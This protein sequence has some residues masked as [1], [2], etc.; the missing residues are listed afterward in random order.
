MAT[1][2]EK[3]AA[4]KKAA[5]AAKAKEDAKTPEQRK[6]D[7]KRAAAIWADFVNWYRTNYGG[8]TPSKALKDKYMK[9]QIEGTGWD[10]A[11]AARWIRINDKNYEETAEYKARESAFEDLYGLSFG[12]GKGKLTKQ[13]LKWLD[14]FG[15]ADPTDDADA[16]LLAFFSKHIKG[17]KEF[18]D[19]HPGFQAFVDNDISIENDLK[20][21]TAYN[22]KYQDLLAVWRNEGI[23]GDMDPALVARAMEENWDPAGTQ[24]YAAIRGSAGYAGT[25]SYADRVADFKEQWAAI[26]PAGYDVD[27]SLMNKY[28]T[29]TR[30]WDEFLRTDIKNSAVFQAAYPDYAS[31][32]E[33]Q[34]KIGGESNVEGQVD[35]NDYFEARTNFIEAWEKEYTHGEAID[36][37]LLAQA[38]AG[39]WSITK[40]QNAMRQLPGFAQTDEGKNKGAAF[41]SYWRGLFGDMSPVDA[42]LRS[43][44]LTGDYTDPSAMWDQIKKSST[45]QSQYQNWD[46]YATAQ[47]A[48]G[49]NVTEDPMAYKEYQAAF[50]KAFAD[51]GMNV[52][53]GMDREIFASGLNARDIQTNAEDYVQTREDY[54]WQTGQE[55]DVRQAVG[56]GGAAGGDLRMRLKQALEQHRAY[57]NSRFT[58]ADKDK[59]QGS[60]LTTNK[61]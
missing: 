53:A 48:A 16:V 58:T 26:F 45:F 33:A 2:A 13:E 3:T 49:V 42:A 32:E 52:P 10:K 24:W 23:T 15:R 4:E 60:G 39:N 25:Q 7:K 40:F 50:Y 28:A 43:T 17:T 41:D 30:G 47:A 57:A 34:H 5:A 36:P 56:L 31:W 46:A 38:M 12:R 44:Y 11:F 37:A 29:G 6:A 55:A 27:Q 8:H 20:G 19:R 1:E 59:T 21:L 22:L 54:A 9:G 51:I 14:A 61:I 18:Q 35:I